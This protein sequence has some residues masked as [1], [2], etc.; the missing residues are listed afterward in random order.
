MSRKR[1]SMTAS[2]TTSLRRLDEVYRKGSYS[3][4][5][6]KLFARA[7]IRATISCRGG[8]G[9]GGGKGGAAE[10]PKPNPEGEEVEDAERR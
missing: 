5:I 2:H 7:T 9:G 3:V 4:S 6:F 8:G 10:G 1:T